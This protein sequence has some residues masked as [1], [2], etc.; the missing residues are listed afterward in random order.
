MINRPLAYKGPVDHLT[1]FFSEKSLIQG[2]S[3]L[4]ETNLVNWQNITDEKYIKGTCLCDGQFTKQ[5][6]YWPMT[7]AVGSCSCEESQSLS[8]L[9]AFPCAHLAALAIE[10]KTRLHRLPPSTNQQMKQVSGK[11]Y[12]KRWLSKQKL[13]PFPA[14]ARH[15]VIYLLHKEV[16]YWIVEVVKA[17]LTKES[18]FQ[19]KGPIN[20]QEAIDSEIFGK[21][22]TKFFS[23]ADQQIL[24]YVSKDAGCT[25]PSDGITAS[26]G[27]KLKLANNQFMIN[28]DQSGNKIIRALANTER[29]FWQSSHRAALNLSA[30]NPNFWSDTQS[31]DLEK[32]SKNYFLDLKHN[33]II[34]IF[35]EAA[36][37]SKKLFRQLMNKKNFEIQPLMKVTSTETVVPWR[38]EEVESFD[39]A[40]IAFLVNGEEFSLKNL[41]PL[42]ME[43]E[44]KKE[45]SEQLANYLLQIENLEVLEARYE[46]P[47]IEKFHFGDR[48]FDSHLSHMLPILNGMFE[49]GWKIEIDRGFRLNQISTVDW[50][51]EI[52]EGTDTSVKT[53]RRPK[54]K[55]ADNLGQPTQ[56]NLL[57]EFDN[58]AEVSS[59]RQ[60]YDWFDLEVGVKVK[61]RSINLMPYIVSLIQR[62]E[63]DFNTPFDETKEKK[64]KIK[65]DSGETLALE[66]QRVHS[67]FSS[68]VELNDE[69]SLNSD[70]RLRL[71]K[72]QFGR[73][74]PLLEFKGSGKS[75][76]GKQK[77]PK[78]DWVS[79]KHLAKKA[80]QLASDKGIKTISVPRE[81][82]GE[83]RDYQHFG[84]NWLQ[85][86]KKHQ[87][88]G[89]LADDMGLGKTIQTITH[90]LVEKKES[91]LK[92][93]CLVIAP[94]TLLSNWEQEARKFAPSLK[95]MKLAGGKR[96]ELYSKI[97]NM[98]LIVTSYGL[99]L[100]DINKLQKF[101]FSIVI[102]DEA[103]VIKNTRSKITTA[104][105]EL[106]SDQRICLTG[107]PMENHLGE[108]WSLFQFLMPGFLGS[109]YQFNQ[110]YRQPIEKNQDYHRQ[111][112]LA[113][114]V[115][116]LMLRRTKNEVA[117][118]LPS[119][120][121]MVT[122]IE[123]EQ[124]QADLY[125][126]IRIS[127][128]EQV[129]KAMS[130]ETKNRNQFLIGNALL[131]L[132]QV[133]CHS[134]LIKLESAQ[135]TNSSAKIAWLK[136]RL[137]TMVAQGRRILLF[138]SFTSMLDI[139]AE[140]LESLSLPFLMLTGK[141][142]HRGKMVE[143][144]QKSEIPIFLISLKAGGVGLNLTAADTVI[145]YDP[146][147]NP[148]AEQQA[149]DRAY[150]IGQDKPVFVYKLITKGTVEEK[151]QQMQQQK[152]KLA[153][154][155]YDQESLD[156]MNLTPED[157]QALFRPI[158]GY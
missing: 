152:H 52:N 28:F 113:K 42:V 25:R 27:S 92:T 30:R 91:R 76:K 82:I 112:L 136:D 84:L 90:V 55:N 71:P 34:E 128:M 116:P 95:F 139:I 65:L 78:I 89:I 58:D 158:E 79:G 2:L 130:L 103:Q 15:R 59:E 85:F 61:G 3:I 88:G 20:I 19:P 1:H 73:L 140:E 50:Y 72:S 26:D 39:V 60:D 148:A 56:L 24:Y 6:L 86:L 83:L 101:R 66:K 80:K 63:L 18:E 115:A 110:L 135:K 94:T 141:S 47:L 137:P 31:T 98:D 105:N 62:E 99:V 138:S 146:W 97:P 44:A 64:V 12:I 157:W 142:K 123:L 57:S 17:Y 16:D 67:I 124:A 132:R 143:Q 74:V 144:F 70:S 13:D 111:T 109:E 36:E 22:Q 77:L 69:K 118:E 29:L 8:N 119:K 53:K 23:L 4:L 134:K 51:I 104:V 43:R 155:L 121:E 131:K 21:K 108:L 126:T 127:M 68:F 154:G 102:L 120:T 9:E 133:C 149:N 33:S 5:I 32:I 54:K 107:T 114:R 35:D 129:D 87:L 96:Q 125:E 46:L 147:W 150:R 48:E 45:F 106:R 40:K 153:Q 41:L 93:P 10:S 151:I 117:K 122:L 75:K 81:L 37:K 11:R 100:R 49:L 145:H 38:P 14:M 7:E 156:T